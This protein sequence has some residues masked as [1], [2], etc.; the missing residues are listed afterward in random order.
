MGKSTENL[1]TVTRVG[2]DLAKKGVTVM[3][4]TALPAK[5]LSPLR[6]CGCCPR[7][8]DNVFAGGESR[9]ILVSSPASGQ[10]GFGRS[11]FG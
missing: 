4:W 7:Q 3:E 11:R 1:A 5:L 9:A 10:S 2:V 8:A 6:K